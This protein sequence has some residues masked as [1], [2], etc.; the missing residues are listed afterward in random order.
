MPSDRSIRV[1]Y[2]AG[3]FRA[4]TAY[5]R[6]QNIRRAEAVALDIMRLGYAVICPHAL[7]RFTFG[8]VPEEQVMAGLIELMRRCDAVVLVEGW[9]RSPGT[10]REICEAVG[11]GMPVFD[12]AVM[13]T[14][15]APIPASDLLEAAAALAAETRERTER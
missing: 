5:E 7:G 6:E 1:L 12:D 10:L 4:A 14:L 3:P 9:T 13:F 11:V 8:A 2:V 15:N